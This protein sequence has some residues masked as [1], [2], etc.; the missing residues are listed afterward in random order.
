MSKTKK[1]PSYP[2]GIG[3]VEEEADGSRIQCELCGNWYKNLGIHAH[4]GHG[5]T[6]DEYRKHFGLAGGLVSQ[7]S[8]EKYQKVGKT[9]GFLAQYRDRRPD[10]T[11]RK[12]GPLSPQTKL[13][14]SQAQKLRLKLNPQPKGI[15][16]S[17]KDRQAISEGVKEWHHRR[18]DTQAGTTDD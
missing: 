2:D 3:V 10:M 1:S 8:K 13:R 5:I 6:A 16:R 14:I 4:H 12:L 11:G 17:E 18:R 7:A 9:K 15:P